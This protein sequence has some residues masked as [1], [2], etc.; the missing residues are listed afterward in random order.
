MPGTELQRTP[1]LS[2][3]EH[4][5]SVWAGRPWQPG[6]VAMMFPLPLHSLHASLLI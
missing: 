6:Q 4:P 1:P 5:L 2:H 3:L